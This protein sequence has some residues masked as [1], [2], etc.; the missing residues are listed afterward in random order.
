MLRQFPLPIVIE[1]LAKDCAATELWSPDLFKEKYGDFEVCV[2]NT[3]ALGSSNSRA[4][5]AEI[6]DE[7]QLGTTGGRYVQNISNLFLEYPELEQQLPLT[8]IKACLPDTSRLFGI[9]LFLGG[10]DT[11]SHYHCAKGVNFFVNVFGEKEWT[12]VSPHHS[13]WMYPKMHVTG[14]HFMSAV[15]YR[16][17]PAEQ[18]ETFPLYSQV[19]IFKAHLRA[20]DVLINVPWWWH[21]IKNL[22]P[23]TIAC[24]TRWGVPNVKRTNPL[25]ATC[26]NLSPHILT[27]VSKEFLLNP[28]ARMRDEMFRDV[29]HKD[30]ENYHRF[31]HEQKVKR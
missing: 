9:Q 17:T 13:V 23:I 6:V 8:K 5:L 28:N 15:D 20:G 16:K 10:S 27:K 2:D 21:A 29:Y 22:T 30:Y 4:T 7:I 11:G 19:P 26:G 12:F 1:G 31:R 3:Y 25:Y 14:I 18:Q 24:S